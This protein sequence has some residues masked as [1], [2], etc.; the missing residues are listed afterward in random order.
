[1]NYPKYGEGPGPHL[2]LGW[3][4]ERIGLFGGSFDPPTLAHVHVAEQL[5]EKGILD[6]VLFVPAY[7]SYH[8]KNYI[9]TPE[10]R[11][12]MLKIVCE[13][14]EYPLGVCTYEIDNKMQ[15]CTYDFVT[16][17][18]KWSEDILEQYEVKIDEKFHFI[19][20]MDNAKMIPRFKHGDKLMN[21]IPF[22][23]VN[24]G[25]DKPNGDEWFNNEP[26]QVIDIG[27]AHNDCSSSKIREIMVKFSGYEFMPPLFFNEL[28]DINVFSYML[29]EELYVG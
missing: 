10:Q 28:C 22:V 26:H 14:S 6:R 4:T 1:M 16:K 2:S 5:I 24:R 27:N 19:V 12:E 11:I 3:T 20:G 9:A 8:K 7:V 18:T 25:G 23:V 21:E 17:F 15:T 13:K 29:D